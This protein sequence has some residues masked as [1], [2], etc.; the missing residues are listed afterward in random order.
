MGFVSDFVGDITG[1]NDA[2]DAAKDASKIQADAARMGIEEQRRQFDKL[3]ELMSPYVNAG[4]G[5]LGGQ[6][7]LLGLSGADAQR[8]AIN[9]LS[10]SPQFQSLI[11]QGENAMLQN[12]SATGGLRGGNI[13][14]AMSQFRPQILSQLIDQQFGRLGGLT[15]VGQAAAAGQAAAGQASG[16]NIAEL[17]QQMG[18]ANAG[19]TLAAGGARRQGFGDLLGIG[20]LI[21]GF[22]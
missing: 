12:A 18:A 5:A 16:N 14:A 2:A 19:G 22:F 13:Q 6:Q 7:D 21:G 9:A 8:K 10:A 20:S 11:Q 4:V 1:A 3:V 15:Q 17:L